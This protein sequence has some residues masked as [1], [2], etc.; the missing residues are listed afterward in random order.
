MMINQSI[1]TQI[2]SVDAA[3][4][5]TGKVIKNSTE[6]FTGYQSKYLEVVRQTTPRL[7][8]IYRAVFVERLLITVWATGLD[9]S[10]NRL[11]AKTFVQSLRIDQ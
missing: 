1:D 4:G 9:T 11:Q 5:V 7:Y 3:V 8:G 10:D 2:A 6:P